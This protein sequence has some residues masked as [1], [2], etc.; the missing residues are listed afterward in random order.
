MASTAQL[1]AWRRALQRER[2]HLAAALAEASTAQTKIAQLDQK[3]A[4]AERRGRRGT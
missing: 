2:K 3:I 4:A 1:A